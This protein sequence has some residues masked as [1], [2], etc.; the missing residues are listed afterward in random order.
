MTR[1]ITFASCLALALASGCPSDDDDDAA[2]D[3]ADD[4]ETDDDDDAADDAASSDDGVA[5]SDDGAAESSTG[6]DLDAL[7]DCVDPMITEARPLVGPGYDPAMGGLVDPQE[8]YI[9]SATQILVRPEKQQEFFEVASQVSAEL[10]Q[11][12]GMV[13]YALAIEPT[14]GFSR[15]ISVYR[16]QESMIGFV[17]SEAHSMAMQRSNELGITGKVTHWEMSADE[18]PPTWETARE[19]LAEIDPFD[20]Y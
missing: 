6:L 2:D 15:T 14:C 1:T 3:A 9:V 8:T 7:Y 18:F 12:E 5:T 20:G 11:S 10:D 17:A 4:D 16:S 13:A 19:H